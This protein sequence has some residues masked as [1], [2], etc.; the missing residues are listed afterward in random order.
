MLRDVIAVLRRS[1][2]DPEVVA[3]EPVAVDVPITIDTRALVS[4]VND[5]IRD[6][7][8][9]VMMADLPLITT[10]VVDRL[11]AT[12]GDVVL[13]P[14]RGGGTNA[15]VVRDAAF[16]LTYH[17]ISF[18]AN[19]GRANELDLSLGTV[20]S[21]RLATDIDEPEDLLEVLLHADGRAATWLH[22][23]DFPSENAKPV[24]G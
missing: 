9:A 16:D 1:G 7:P 18:P 4:A 10:D 24:V 2:H 20:D 13:A 12:S 17:D 14:G 21:Y 23:A 3:T 19:C 8:I 15:A 6:P 5:S 11:L 22:E